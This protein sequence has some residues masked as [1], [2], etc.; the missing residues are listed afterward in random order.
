MDFHFWTRLVLQPQDALLQIKPP[1][2]LFSA[3]KVWAVTG[4]WAGLV[5]GL[6]GFLTGGFTG[7]SVISF[8]VAILIS[9]ILYPILYALIEGLYFL[10]ARVLGGTGSFRD[11][12]YFVGLTGRILLPLSVMFTSFHP[13][14]GFFAASLLGLFWLYPRTVVYRHVHGFDWFKA[15]LVWL[16]PAIV[17]TLLGLL[18]VL[19][20]L[21]VV[22]TAVASA[23]ALNATATLPAANP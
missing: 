9:P 21:G 15:V 8:F 14:I 18:L 12:Y 23:G 5:S 10:V 16:L 19:L 20:F 17:F 4:F 22:M 6:V 2:D 1:S 13:L 3:I 11:Q 7:L